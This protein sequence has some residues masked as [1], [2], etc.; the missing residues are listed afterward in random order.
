M[1]A[2]IKHY[3]E[4]SDILAIRCECN[5]C[6]AVLTLPLA[7]DVGASLLACPRCGEGW[8]RQKNST[9]ELLISEF[10]QKAEQ[11]ATA[12]PYMGLTL[13]LEIKPSDSDED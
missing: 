4:V 2:Q 9:S 3:I 10:A 8:A 12:V 5:R 1:T 13:M 6:H 11:L 7:K